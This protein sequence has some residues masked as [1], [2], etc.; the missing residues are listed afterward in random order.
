MTIMAANMAGSADSRCH[1]RTNLFLSAMVEEDGL[2]E[3]VRIRN[4]SLMGAMI[5]GSGLPG[6]G[7]G[8][9]LKRGS[10]EVRC[11]IMWDAGQKRGLR[12]AAPVPVESWTGKIGVSA[13]QQRVDAIQAAIRSGASLATQGP[14]APPPPRVPLEGRIAEELR[15]LRRIVE[16]IGDDLSGDLETLQRHGQ[17][18]QQLDRASQIL[19]HLSEV[20]EAS[21]KRAAV[22]A[23]AMSDLRARL[24]AGPRPL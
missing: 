1:A 6:Q 8:V 15:Q 17:S 3:V 14:S 4:L 16:A 7:K 18:L 20:I 9:V 12:F 22:E 13:G 11:T 24:G 5:E 10:V 2:A 21:D 23:I 19:G